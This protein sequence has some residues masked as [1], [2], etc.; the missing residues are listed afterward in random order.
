VSVAPDA[1]PT[2][3]QANRRLLQVEQISHDCILAEEAFQKVNRAIQL[4]S[5]RASALHFGDP[6]AQALWSAL[7][8]FQ[9]FP[10]GFSNRNLRENLAPLL[11]QQPA[12]LTQGLMTYHLPRLASPCNDRTHPQQSPLPRDRPWPVHGMVLYTH[13]LPRSFATGWAEYCLS[14]PVRRPAP[15]LLR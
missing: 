13:L 9:L 11:G 7:L 4:Q 6:Q 8:L 1:G 2:G 10:T 14:F 15:P 5:Q 3:F 12:D